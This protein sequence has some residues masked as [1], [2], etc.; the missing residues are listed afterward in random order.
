MLRPEPSRGEAALKVAAL[1]A[2]S[3]LATKNEDWCP[4]ILVR[5]EGK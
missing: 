5:R 3:A 2:V 4:V 1:S